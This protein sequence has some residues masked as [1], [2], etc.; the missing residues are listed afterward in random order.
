M[1]TVW[2]ID[3]YSRPIL[4][5]NQK[6][7]WELL[8]CDTQRS[9][10]FCKYCAG[11]QANARW[12]Q[13]ALTEAMDAWRQAQQLPAPASP[14][15]IRFFRRQMNSIITR[16]CAA[17]SIP[18]QPSKR[19]FAI[20]QWLQERTQT[21][22]PQHPGFQPTMAPPP[23]YEPVQPR[24]LPDALVGQGW[25]V[26][27]LPAHAFT[28]MDEWEVAFKDAVPLDLLTLAPDAMVP[29]HLGL[30]GAGHAASGVDGRVG[31]VLPEVG[32]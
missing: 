32:S 21:V 9:F 8:V 28:E 19:T 27:T 24:P 6:K 4:D 1:T 25:S 5:D 23:Q 17:L 22:Y 11:A 14:T 16:A 13:A 26:A 20:Y 30:F 2:E 12:L 3:F 29:R 31:V 7:L 15:K 18:A 10:E